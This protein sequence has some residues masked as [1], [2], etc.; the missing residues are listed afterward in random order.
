[1]TSEPSRNGTVGRARNDLRFPRPGLSLVAECLRDAISWPIQ[2]AALSDARCETT[3]NQVGV[4][5]WDRNTL[6]DA[7]LVVQIITTRL[8]TAVRHQQFARRTHRRVRIPFAADVESVRELP[9][10]RSV[11]DFLDMHDLLDPHRLSGWTAMRLHHILGIKPRQLLELLSVLESIGAMHVPSDAPA[12]FPGLNVFMV[13]A[14]IR[15][16]LDRIEARLGAHD[17][18]ATDA[19]FSSLLTQLLPSRVGSLKGAIG[20]LRLGI[21]WAGNR[22][23]WA[24]VGPLVHTIDERLQEMHTA[25]L[26][27]DLKG[28]IAAVLGP[29]TWRQVERVSLRLGWLDGRPHT[30]REVGAICGISADVTRRYER[31]FRYRMQNQTALCPRLVEAVQLV[32]AMAPCAELEA[33]KTLRARGLTH[34]QWTMRALVEAAN[35][36]RVPLKFV[37]VEGEGDHAMICCASRERHKFVG[38]VR[39]KGSVN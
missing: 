19:R 7:R 8:G 30:L 37:I 26:E 17:V 28:I 11:L 23:P 10:S 9:L 39:K 24:R 35:V 36:L 4:D 33:A 34:N 1:M 13:P 12:D 31:T 18:G 14:H 15:V 3:S 21:R 29:G 32:T 6:Q 20:A 38:R 16:L 5:F 25:T 27:E 22:D 2:H